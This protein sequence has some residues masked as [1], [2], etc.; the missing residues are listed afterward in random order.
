MIQTSITSRSTSTASLSRSRENCEAN[1]R[2]LVGSGQNNG[3][4][5]SGHSRVGN[6]KSTQRRLNPTVIWQGITQGIPTMAFTRSAAILTL[7]LTVGCAPQLPTPDALAQDVLQRLIPSVATAESVTI[8]ASSP[9]SSDTPKD[10]AVKVADALAERI[11]SGGFRSDTQPQVRVH[12]TRDEA[13]AEDATDITLY[14]HVNDH[15]LEGEFAN[16]RVAIKKKFSAD[17]YLYSRDSKSPFTMTTSF[18]N[19][20]NAAPSESTPV[21]TAP[22]WE[23]SGYSRD[24]DARLQIFAGECAD[25]ILATFHELSSQ[26]KPATE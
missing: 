26:V 18:E 17:S 13:E 12:R 1:P 9:T 23:S 8:I 3:L 16:D 2:Q 14:F 24:P 19:N 4:Q 25:A 10:F 22:T 21:T 11:A 20:L 6:G 5:Q 7:F 15:Q